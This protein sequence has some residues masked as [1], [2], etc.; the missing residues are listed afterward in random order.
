MAKISTPALKPSMYRH[1]AALTVGVTLVLVIFAD[2]ENRDAI[3]AEIEAQQQADAAKDA[4]S[5]PR[6]GTPRLKQKQRAARWREFNEGDSSFGDPTDFTGSRV[7][8]TG[9]IDLPAPS[10]LGGE[11]TPQDYARFGVSQAELAALSPA[12]REKLLA[13]L[14]A[15]GLAADPEERAEQIEKLLASSAQRSGGQAG[16]E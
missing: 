2:G 7:Q 8:R 4:A 3:A 15:G 6:Y 5:K 1:F 11:F 9:G 16:L 12:E 13:K 14:R 10:R